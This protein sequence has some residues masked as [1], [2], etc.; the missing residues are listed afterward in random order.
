MKLNSSPIGVLD[1]GVG[2]LTVVRRIREFLPGET[3]LY[4]GD[5]GRLPYGPKPMEEVRRYVN[6]IVD[7]L[8]SKGAK[9]IIIACNTATAAALDSAAA[10]FKGPVAG[11]IEPGAK[12]AVEAVGRDGL[13][14]LIATQGTVDSEAYDYDLRR[15][16]IYRP[17]IKKAC[18]EF[19]LLVEKGLTD[20]KEVKNTVEKCL[21]VFKKNPIDALILGCTHFPLLS[22]Y[23]SAALPGVILVDPAVFT[24]K[25]IG[26]RLK[27][28]SLLCEKKVGPGDSFFTT[29]NVEPFR[30][31]LQAILGEG[32]YSV[33]KVEF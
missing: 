29:G 7:F 30:D 21:E 20:I 3:V 11:V 33:E 1:S 6:Q 22:E 32:D 16:G 17:L 15:M 31:K 25:E 13:I 2:G 26:E 8:G 24:V 28:Q 5:T 23:I 27:T 12:A 14:G 10:R 19:V 4:F 9:A 18:P